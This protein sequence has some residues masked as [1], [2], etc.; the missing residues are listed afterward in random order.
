MTQLFGSPDT[1]E[2]LRI[3]I[4]NIDNSKEINVSMRKKNFSN[5]N[6]D[7]NLFLNE[8]EEQEL[9][10]QSKNKKNNNNDG[11]G[12]SNNNTNNNDDD[13]DGNGKRPTNNTSGPST[14]DFTNDN[15]QKQKSI[16]D[17]PMDTTDVGNES[18]TS[19][20]TLDIELLNKINE[21]FSDFNQITNSN[22]AIVQDPEQILTQI[23]Q[24][25]DYLKLNKINT[26]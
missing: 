13:D 20:H 18:T 16:N 7:S 9:K 14:S 2:D 26:N 24:I 19:K 4:S 22:I 6:E 11:S 23:K 25:I 10:K 1:L 17:I 3:K 12:P 15:N 21:M 8:F 5:I